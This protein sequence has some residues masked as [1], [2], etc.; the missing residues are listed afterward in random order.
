MF[1]QFMLNVGSRHK[2]THDI[3]VITTLN[4]KY[5]DQHVVSLAQ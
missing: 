1:I 3:T 2:L 5:D 4:L